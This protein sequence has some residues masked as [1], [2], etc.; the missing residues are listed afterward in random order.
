MRKVNMANI[1]KCLNRINPFAAYNPGKWIPGLRAGWMFPFVIILILVLTNPSSAYIWPRYDGYLKMPVADSELTLDPA[2]EMTYEEIGLFFALYD[3]LFY[4]NN[5]NQVM[6]NLA[7]SFETY[8]QYRRYVIRLNQ[9]ATFHDGSPVT[10]QAVADSIRRNHVRIQQKSQPYDNIQSIN[11]L[12]TYTL[13]FHLNT[14]DPDLPEKLAHPFCAIIKGTGEEV[15]SGSTK[16]FHYI[17]SGPFKLDEVSAQ[18]IRLV[19]NDSYHRGRPYLRSIEFQI[20]KSEE[21]SFLKF[22][23]GKL[24]IHRV[25]YKQYG[26]L[27]RLHGINI[28]NREGSDTIIL[29]FGNN[30]NKS[31]LIKLLKPVEIVNVVMNH[32][33]SGVR[34]I[35]PDD[36]TGFCNPDTAGANRITDNNI[37]LGYLGDNSLLE[38]IA[39]RIETEWEAS[40]LDVSVIMLDELP[41]GICDAVLRIVKTMRQDS[42]FIWLSTRYSLGAEGVF[43]D[44][45]DVFENPE[46]LEEKQLIEDM[47]FFP[48][49]RPRMAFALSDDVVNFRLIAGC[50]PD[51]WSISL[52]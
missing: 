45:F 38:P 18:R 35:L 19:A 12:D 15:V 27:M 30:I 39:R 21:D 14:A 51:F 3:C 25:P 28:A 24:H 8:E 48:I 37:V 31:A 43:Y 5:S 49:A 46:V 1:K 6:P 29:D 44:S 23:S 32:A 26:E 16:V 50:V 9:N 4:I 41:S 13:E 36:E 42:S 22:A 33:G 10:A 2:H 52:K 11:T 47:H 17:G 34:G 7:E 40:G 20:I